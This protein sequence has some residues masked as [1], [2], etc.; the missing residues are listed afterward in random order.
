MFGTCIWAEFFSKHVFYRINRDLSQ[1]C[2]SQIHNPHITLDYNV[3]SVDL[4]KY[5][6]TE[7]CKLGN[8]YQSSN[9]NF[10]SLQQDYLSNDLILYHVSLAYKVDTKFTEKDIMFA[11][12]LNI[13]TIIYPKELKV[14]SWNCDSIYTKDWYEIN[15][16]SQS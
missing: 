8:I 9:K 10:H 6:L 3:N 4:N 12:T 13:P 1:H 15:Q 14:S 2:K 7:L 11:S 16:Q 5:K